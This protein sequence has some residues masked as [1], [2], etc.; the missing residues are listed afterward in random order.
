[1]VTLVPSDYTFHNFGYCIILYCKS[2]YMFWPNWP[3]SGVYVVCLR[4]L[5]FCFSTIIALGSFH[6]GII[7]CLGRVQFI[8]N[9]DSLI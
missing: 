4:K 9:S 6:V 3:S 5:L 8:C 1:M 2:N 7:C